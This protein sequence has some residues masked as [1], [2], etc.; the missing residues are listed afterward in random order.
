MGTLLS[1]IS[2]E[3]TLYAIRSILHLT[4]HELGNIRPHTSKKITFLNDVL[5][6]VHYVKKMIK[7]LTDLKEDWNEETQQFLDRTLNTFQFNL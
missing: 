4:H 3:L 2:G 1:Y 5:V 6:N 7:L